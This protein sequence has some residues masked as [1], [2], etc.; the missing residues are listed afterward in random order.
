[1]EVLEYKKTLRELNWKKLSKRIVIAWV[2]VIGIGCI[3]GNAIIMLFL[4]S[5][6]WMG[7]VFFL[8]ELSVPIIF[9]E[10]VACIVSIFYCIYLF[11]KLFKSAKVI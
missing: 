5:A 9:L 4:M 6:F 7:K 1:M 3:I 11:I 10:T 2:H 8:Y